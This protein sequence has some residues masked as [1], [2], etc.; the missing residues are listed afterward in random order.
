MAEVGVAAPLLGKFTH[1]GVQTPY[2]YFACAV[3]DAAVPTAVLVHGFG[4]RGEDLYGHAGALQALGL[5]V[6]VPTMSSLMAGAAAQRRNIGMVVAQVRALTDAADPSGLRHGGSARADPARLLLIG[7]SAG[8]AVVAEAAAALAEA[9]QPVAALLLYDAVPWPRTHTVLAHYAPQGTVV[10]SL[11]CAPSAWNLQGA[12]AAA[13]APVT[14]GHPAQAIDLLV[15][16]AR[17]GDPLLPRRETLLLRALGLLGT[18]RAAD[19]FAE[20]TCALGRD[21]AAL[22]IT[23]AAAAGPSLATCTHT[24]ELLLTLVASHAVAIVS[25]GGPAAL[26][27]R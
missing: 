27:A 6:L 7:H 19:V 9:Q 4:G 16:G 18:V 25:G 2:A 26:Q 10:V 3:H 24:L 5:A 23:T 20:V 1:A 22:A 12:L 13:L 8:G 14:Q 11:R 21:V 15:A 17:H